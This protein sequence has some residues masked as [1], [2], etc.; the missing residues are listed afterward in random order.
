MLLD[1][2][3]VPGSVDVL[4]TVPSGVVTEDDINTVVAPSEVLLLLLLLL[5]L[6]LWY[7]LRMPGFCWYSANTTPTAQSRQTAT[8]AFMLA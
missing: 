6:K 1:T 7:S 8:A 5:E 3:S 2:A 4:V